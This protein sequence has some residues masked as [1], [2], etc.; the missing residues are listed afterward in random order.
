M[1]PD[2]YMVEWTKRKQTWVH[3]HADEPTAADQA[4]LMKGTI[5]PLY[6]EV[7][8]DAIVA[9]LRKGGEHVNGVWYPWDSEMR[10]YASSFADRIDSGDHRS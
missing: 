5:T 9:F 1:A 2:G 10:G 7:E 6:K 8:K 4:R 3:I